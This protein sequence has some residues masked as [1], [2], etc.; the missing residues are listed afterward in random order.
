[1]ATKHYVDRMEVQFWKCSTR[2][3]FINAFDQ[4]KRKGI[5]KVLALEI[6]DDLYH[7]CAEEFGE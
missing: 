7:A 5:N 3:T 1:M 6:L 4:M 2:D